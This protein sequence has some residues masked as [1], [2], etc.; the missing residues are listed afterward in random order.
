[1]EN[2]P[3]LCGLA[4]TLAEQKDIGVLVG[5][6]GLHSYYLQYIYLFRTGYAHNLL[7]IVRQLI[8]HYTF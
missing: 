1:M 8:C 5:S 7:I 6:M 4:C 3:E 2:G